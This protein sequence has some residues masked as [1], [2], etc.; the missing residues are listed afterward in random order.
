MEE[1][2]QEPKSEAEAREMVD[3]QLERMMSEVKRKLKPESKNQL[4]RTICALLLDNYMLKAKVAE[5]NQAKGESSE[6]SN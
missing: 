1:S 5:L 4:I 6:A 3:G 2:K